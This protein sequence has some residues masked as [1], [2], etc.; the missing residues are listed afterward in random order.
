MDN[1]ERFILTEAKRFI[2]E[3]GKKHK[4]MVIKSN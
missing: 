3:E 4:I 2:D 1:L